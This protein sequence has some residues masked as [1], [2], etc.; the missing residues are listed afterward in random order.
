MADLHETGHPPVTAAVGELFARLS[1]SGQDVVWLG[2]ELIAITQH[3]GSVAREMVRDATGVRSL[4]CRSD[5]PTGEPIRFSDRGPLYVF[6]PLLARLAV[7]CSDETGQAFL[8]YGGR[9]SLTRSSRDGPVRLDLDFANTPSEQRVHITRVAVTPA[10]PS[11]FGNGSA[12]HS[13]SSPQPAG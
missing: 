13:M 10:A 5:P 11:A 3:V 8:P 4:V 6:R 1:V 7:M 12:A 9:Y 2:D